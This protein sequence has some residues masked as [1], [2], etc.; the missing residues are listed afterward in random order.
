M[1]N[2]AEAFLTLEVSLINHV[3]LILK[4]LFDL[5]EIIAAKEINTDS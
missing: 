5:T 1:P 4:R 3:K 2:A